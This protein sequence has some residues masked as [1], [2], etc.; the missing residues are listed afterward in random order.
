LI[1]VQLSG[2]KFVIDE[3]ELRVR[4]EFFE[5]GKDPSFWKRFK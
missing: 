1:S 4:S 5:I 2:V 3:S